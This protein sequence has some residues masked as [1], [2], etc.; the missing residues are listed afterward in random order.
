MVIV[1][2]YSLIAGLIIGCIIAYIWDLLTDKC[3]ELIE[4]NEMKVVEK[5]YKNVFLWYN[6]YHVLRDENATKLLFQLA[7]TSR[8]H[9]IMLQKYKEKW[10]K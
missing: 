7:D 10:G 2:F 6:Q 1:W 8:K 4:K 5:G 9:Q 3:L